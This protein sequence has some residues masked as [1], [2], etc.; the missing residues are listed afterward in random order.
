MIKKINVL[1]SGNVSDIKDANTII[2]KN[3]EYCAENKVLS[4]VET[5]ILK[6]YIFDRYSIYS[7]T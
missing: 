2:E 4:R 6:L 5:E 3:I 7:Y 1:I